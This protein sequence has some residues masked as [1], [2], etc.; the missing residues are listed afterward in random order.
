METRNAANAGPGYTP[1]TSPPPEKASLFE[2]YIDILHAPATVFGRRM[3]AGFGV[4]LLIVS[5]L[6][7]ALL[8][9]SRSV[10][11]QIMEAQIA[12]AT[13]E[14]MRNNP[15]LTP[16][17]M[18]QGR[19]IQMTIGNIFTYLG[20]PIYLLIFTVV[21][22]VLAR[23]VGAKIAFRQAGF[24]TM[25]SYVPRLIGLLAVT[26]QV[27]LMD[28]SNVTNMGQVSISP[29]RFMDFNTADKMTYGAAAG[30]DVFNI[31]SLIIMAIG[32]AVMGKV[33]RARGYIAA[34]VMLVVSIG[35]AIVG[36]R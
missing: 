21:T 24:I 22:W 29:A 18:E 25:L 1:S 19:G 13:A 6:T 30:L 9:A 12:K 3:N 36:S 33:P 4:H 5:V 35:L 26:A 14:A 31:W 17:M 7:A 16:E 10:M 32:I 34:A 15:N 23:I 2:D 11:T 27:A 8:F 28:T 20:T